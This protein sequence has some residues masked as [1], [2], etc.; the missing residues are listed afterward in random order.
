[1][2]VLFVC[3]GNVCRSAAA[4]KLLRLYSGAAFEARS[5]GTAAQP[6]YRMPA[7][8]ESF[9]K[10]EGVADTAHK[11]SLVTETDIDWADLVLAMEAHH[12]AL[13]AEKFPQS[14]RKTKLFLDYCGAG[15]GLPDPMGGSDENYARI[16][17]IIKDGVL[18]LVKKAAK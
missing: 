3:T 18:E 13:L 11:A 12:E 1:M 16:M 9:L 7:Q 8:V 6:Y 15:G 5:R 2:K 17:E 4:E 14:M 10:A